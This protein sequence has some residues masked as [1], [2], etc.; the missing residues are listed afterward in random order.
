VD[1][2]AAIVS[3]GR[4]PRWGGEVAGSLRDAADRKRNVSRLVGLVR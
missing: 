3:G 1:S 2:V 4:P